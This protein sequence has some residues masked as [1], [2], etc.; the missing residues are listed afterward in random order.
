MI[1]YDAARKLG[2]EACINRLSFVYIVKKSLRLSF[3]N[4]R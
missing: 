1:T 2:V 4:L 3:V